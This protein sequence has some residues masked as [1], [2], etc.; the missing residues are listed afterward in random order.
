MAMGHA[1]MTFREFVEF[2][3]TDVERRRRTFARS[4]DDWPITIIV[5]HAGDAGPHAFDLPPWISNAPA[6]RHAYAEAMAAA[7]GV[8]KPTKIGFIASTWQAVAKDDDDRAPSERPDRY[9]AVIVVA[10]DAEV[11]EGYL[12]RIKR[13]RYGSPLLGPWEEA[14]EVSGWMFDPWRDALR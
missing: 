10:A 13:R 3:K 1:P 4:D 2:A 11:S 14:D 9:E 8:T 5:D 6:L 12:A 7:A